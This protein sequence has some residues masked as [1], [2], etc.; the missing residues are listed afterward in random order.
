MKGILSLSWGLHCCFLLQVYPPP[1]LVRG[2]GRGEA[3]KWRDSDSS[4]AYD[5]CKRDYPSPN[6]H[7]KRP[8]PGSLEKVLEKKIAISKMSMFH[9][10]SSSINPPA[11][12]DLSSSAI[13]SWNRVPAHEFDSRQCFSSWWWFCPVFT[14]CHWT[15][16]SKRLLGNLQAMPDSTRNGPRQVL[17]HHG[18]LHSFTQANRKFS[19][20]LSSREIH[21]C[22]V[23]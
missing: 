16:Y 12:S 21:A 17:N 6:Q 3:A 4:L 11:S 15:V 23:K 13:T 5:S 7:A 2:G 9:S 14:I 20:C 10:S 8:Y 1:P 18:A 19:E 22:L